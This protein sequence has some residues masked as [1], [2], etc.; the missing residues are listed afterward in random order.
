MAHIAVLQKET[1][2]SLNL[3]KDSVVVDCTLGSG[4]HAALIVSA[5]GKNGCF[6]GMDV[7]ETAL[8]A[9]KKLETVTTTKVVLI[10]SNF[11]KIQEILQEQKVSSVDAILADLGWRMEQFDGTSGVPRGF[12]FKND[13]PL[14][15]TFG[16]PSEYSFTAY[17]IVNEWAEEDIA[18]VL[19][20]YGEEFKSRKIAKYIVEA[21]KKAP[22]MTSGQ[23]AEVITHAVCGTKKTPQR[24]HPATKSFQALRIAVNDEFDVLRTLLLSGFEAL[25][26]H[27]RMSIIT[28]HSLEDRIVKETFK[29]FTRDRKGILVTKK[30]IGP[31]PEEVK[32]NPR[33]RSAKLRTIEKL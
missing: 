2:L 17:D 12:S 18:N 30:P 14:H 23:L 13:E 27:G 33:S 8:L 26:P 7:D 21:R 20:A 19:F 4:G 5:L 25:A 15:M 16:K 6:I 11:A 9:N 10:R 31:S 22:I 24:I 1:V 28:F 3:K 32:M 29:N